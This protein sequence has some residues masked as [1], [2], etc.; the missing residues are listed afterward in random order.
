MAAT[1]EAAIGMSKPNHGGG[2]WLYIYCKIKKLKTDY[3]YIS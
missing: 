3:I 1:G 2:N